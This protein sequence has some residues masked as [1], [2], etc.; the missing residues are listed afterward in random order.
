MALVRGADEE[1]LKRRLIGSLTTLCKDLGIL[2]VAEGVETHAERK[3]LTELG[4]NLLQGFLFG[5]PAPA[6]AAAARPKH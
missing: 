2:V 5:R 3:V 4:C 6:R 1:P